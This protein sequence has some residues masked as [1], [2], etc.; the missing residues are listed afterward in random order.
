[1]KFRSLC[2]P[3]IPT[4]ACVC[5]L[6]LACSVDEGAPGMRPAVDGGV[7]GF[8][9]EMEKFS[10][11]GRPLGEAF[12]PTSV[13]AGIGMNYRFVF[14]SLEAGHTDVVLAESSQHCDEGMPAGRMLYI[15]LFEEPNG[16]KSHV[17]EPG[18]FA[19]WLPP[20]RPP[21]DLMLGDRIAV[22][23]YIVNGVDSGGSIQLARAG[24]VVVNTV[25]DSTIAGSFAL[26]IAG[27]KVTGGFETA[28]C[29]NWSGIRSSEIP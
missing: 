6:L 8:S 14:T 9:G 19:V 5:L 25:S 15:A 17:T 27:E 3:R 4:T 11:E 29:G 13:I 20:L 26:D 12:T 28:V 10:V 2:M 16:A 24:S 1:M 18:E 23:S 21:P 22:V 7:D